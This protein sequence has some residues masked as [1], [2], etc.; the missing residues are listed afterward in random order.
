MSII[1]WLAAACVVISVLYYAAASA[2]A[3]AFAR[4]ASGPPPPLP[5]IA[6]RVAILKPLHGMRKSLLENL[7]SYLE[8]DY[9]RV[10]Y[11]F[12]VTTY[13]DRA[14]D[15]PIALKSAQ[16]GFAQITL[17]VGLEPGCENR[18]VA[19]LIRMAERADKA[20]IFVLSDSDVA[21]E[22]DHLRRLVGELCAGEKTGIVTSLYRGRPNGT[23]ASTLEALFVNTDFAPMVIL[24]TAFEPIRYALGATIAIK[25]EAL[26]AIGG[27]R[28]IKDK[29]ADDY[30][31]GKMAAD[32]GYE[33]KLS[34]SIVTVNCEERDFA[35]FWT[36]QIRWARTYRTTRP[37]SV[38]TIVT[39]GPF[40]ALMLLVASGFSGW[41]AGALAAVLAARIGMAAIMLRKVLKLPELTRFAWIVPIKDLIMTAIWFA[42]LASNEVRWSGRRLRINRDGTMREVNG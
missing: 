35:D 3:L 22:R 2:A 10:E 1:F 38:A 4:R 29:L 37:I 13:E 40:W 14:A 8:L 15:V 28:A 33:V 12:A 21:V 32:H 16:Y 30:F 11:L 18:K 25:R 9:P 31:L 41:S 19:K 17:I 5:K 27:F 20:E 34:S 26:E 23:I 36:H 42:S 24:A 39:H 7:T 6:P